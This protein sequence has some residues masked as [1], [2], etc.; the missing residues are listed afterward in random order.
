VA[1]FRVT[2][3]N[4]PAVQRE[5][6]ETLELAIDAVSAHVAAIRS[7]GGLSTVRML[8]TFEPGQRVKARVE[9]STGRFLRRREAGVDVMGDGSVVPYSGGSSRDHLDPLE[10]QRF[11]DL[12][13]EALR[14]PI[15]G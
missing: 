11:E 15:D 6:Y 9:V 7:E 1:A 12:L 2:I 14:K 5:D 8:R 13:T 4:G 10:G 3:R